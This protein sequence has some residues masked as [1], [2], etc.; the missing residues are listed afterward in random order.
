VLASALPHEPPVTLA[1]STNTIVGERDFKSNYNI[2]SKQKLQKFYYCISFGQ[3]SENK[4]E[5]VLNIKID[6]LL[7]YRKFYVCFFFFRF[8]T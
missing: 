8:C 5:L 6:E 2:Y 3:T 7:W 1:A 4:L